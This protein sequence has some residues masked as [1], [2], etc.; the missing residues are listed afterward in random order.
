[1]KIIC[2]G[3][4]LWDLEHVT[5]KTSKELNIMAVIKIS[6]STAIKNCKKE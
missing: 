5:P 3:G 4:L 6:P 1:M 2:N